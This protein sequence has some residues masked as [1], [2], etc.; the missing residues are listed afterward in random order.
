M[1]DAISDLRQRLSH[2]QSHTPSTR[3]PKSDV[4][5]PRMRRC[6]TD[7]GFGAFQKLDNDVKNI[8]RLQDG[9][10]AERT[11]LILLQAMSRGR[12]IGRGR[13]AEEVRLDR[14]SHQEE[15]GDEGYFAAEDEGGKAVA[16]VVEGKVSGGVQIV[17]AE[18][19]EYQGL[20]EVEYDDDFEADELLESAAGL[21]N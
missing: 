4:L 1:A 3:R 16:Q 18:E 6:S 15:R 5:N 11:A 17:R 9:V 2:S 13:A 7:F 20:E 21:E 8:D 19:R 12:I 10:E 14:V